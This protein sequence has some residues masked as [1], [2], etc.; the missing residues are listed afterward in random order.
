MNEDDGLGAPERLYEAL[1]Q[2]RESSEPECKKAKLENAP[3][4]EKHKIKARKMALLLSYCGNGYFGM[5]RLDSS[6]S[7]YFQDI[8]HQMV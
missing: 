3:S 8:S 4:L 7:Q 1:E 6:L 2:A 5:Q